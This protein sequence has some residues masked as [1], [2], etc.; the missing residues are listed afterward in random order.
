MQLGTSL[1][2]SITSSIAQS[3]TQQY[4][5]DHPGVSATDPSA[6]L[7]GFRAAGWT[8]VGA[9]AISVI[10][11]IVGL[12]DIGLVGQKALVEDKDLTDLE[13]AAVGR[14]VQQ[15]DHTISVDL[16]MSIDLPQSTSSTR[17]RKTESSPKN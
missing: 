5:N 11:T 1:G 2:L 12:R 6:L 14:D 16:S 17:T 13:L 7:A 4:V 8:C 3:V 10:I 9:A 15:H